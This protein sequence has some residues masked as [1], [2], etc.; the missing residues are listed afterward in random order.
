MT[1]FQ[2]FGPFASSGGVRG[3]LR[4]ITSA[5]GSAVS[6]ISIDNC[7]STSF[8]HYLVMRDLLGSAATNDLT[9]R[10]RASGAD[11]TGANYRSQFVQG[12]STVVSGAR[13]TAA[14]SWSGG[15]GLTEATSM[16]FVRMWVSNPFEAVRTTAWTDYGGVHTGNIALVSTVLEHDTAS[17]YDGFTVIPSA[18][19]ITGSIFVY[20]LAV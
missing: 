7:F 4:F 16:G 3:D 9:V 2:A 18:G 13:S 11:D 10:L 19:T 8:S 17:S 6:S 15:L 14:T 12:S 20:G 1:L 5:S